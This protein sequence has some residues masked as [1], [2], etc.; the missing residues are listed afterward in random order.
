MH[1]RF[2]TGL[3]TLD[4]LKELRQLPEVMRECFVFS[5]K[6]LDATTIEQLFLVEWSEKKFESFQ[7]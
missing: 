7:G 1:F 4:V 6:P 2:K 3:Q 5:E